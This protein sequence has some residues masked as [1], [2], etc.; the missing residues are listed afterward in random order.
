MTQSRLWFARIVMIY[1]LLT[2]TFL[3]ALYMFEPQNHIAKFGVSISG[4]P[5]SINFLR[6]G[7]GAMFTTL[8][9]TSLYGLVRPQ[10]FLTCLWFVVVLN[11][12]VVAARLYGIDGGRHL[13]D[14]AYRAAG[15]GLIVDR[16]RARAAGLSPVPLRIRPAPLRSQAR[17]SCAGAA[18]R[19]TGPRRRGSAPS[20]GSI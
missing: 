17:V 13:D 2:F 4:V 15:R 18:D 12:C 10:R 20:C 6:A 16:F 14:A 7:P 9:L 11:A 19:R 1:A 8:A 5:E 3:G